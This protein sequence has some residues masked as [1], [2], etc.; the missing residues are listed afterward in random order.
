MGTV[1]FAGQTLKGRVL[2]DR[3][4]ITAFAVGVAAT[5]WLMFLSAWL[6]VRPGALI[7]AR[8]NVLF[9]SDM[10]L[11]VER[12]IGNARSMEQHVHPLELVFWRYPCRLLAHIARLFMPV[13]YAN[14]FGPRLLVATIAGAG[15]GFLAYLALR[16]GVRPFCLRTILRSLF[17]SISESQTDY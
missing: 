14:L 11:W 17:R 16:L 2:A 6:G 8:Q 1:A 3:N 13:D 15:V 10:N 4:V 5:I 7:T 12:M 9:D